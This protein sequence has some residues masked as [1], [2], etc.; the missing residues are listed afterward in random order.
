MFGAFP[1]A[2]LQPETTASPG[3]APLLPPREET[4]SSSA[5]VP[6]WPQ[7]GATTT[8]P[9]TT[10]PAAAPTATPTSIRPP[11]EEVEPELATSAPALEKEEKERGKLSQVLN[12][13]FFK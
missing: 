6:S 12:I 10:T 2:S 7:R 4:T 8:L 3:V 13:F 1:L 9:A 5:V 11:A